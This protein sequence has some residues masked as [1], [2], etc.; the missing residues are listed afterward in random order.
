MYAA[1]IR[2]V[3]LL[4]IIPIIVIGWCAAIHL[5]Y[6]SPLWTKPDWISAIG[7]LLAF[8]GTI[9]LAR[10]A[11]RRLQRSERDRA[12]IASA[13]LLDRLGTLKSSVEWCIGHLEDPRGLPHTRG[14]HPLL[15]LA[16]ALGH[17]QLWTD[18]EILPLSVLPDRITAR[19]A[20]I[21]SKVESSVRDMSAWMEPNIDVPSFNRSVT[22]QFLYNLRLVD[23]SLKAVFAQVGPLAGELHV[24]KRT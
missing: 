11:D 5:L 1:V 14:P 6:V 12:I 13:S 8:G 4:V 21:R 7:T 22:L 10:S 2:F 19:L 20:V 24:I 17:V 3:G 18:E 9:W 15:Q 16:N 23:E